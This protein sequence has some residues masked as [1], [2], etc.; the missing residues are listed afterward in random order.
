M[1][2]GLGVDLGTTSTAAAVVVGDGR[3]ETVAL[4]DRAA[5][6]PSAVFLTDEGSELLG[7]AALRRGVAEPHRLA[8]EFKRRLGDPTPL[9]LGGRPVSAETLSGHLLRWVVDEVRARQGGPPNRIVVTHPANWGP[10]RREVFGQALG[11]AD[12]GRVD[13][14]PEPVAAALH[15]AACERVPSG[16]TVAVYDLGGGT[17]DATVL[18]DTGQGYQVLGSPGGL[19]HLGGVDFDE[20]VLAHVTSSLGDA[21]TDL[22]AD[23]DDVTR[24]LVRL[25]E[26]CTAAKE[27][28][29]SDTEAVLRVELPGV[30]RDVRITRPEFEDLLRP[31]SPRPSPA[32]VGR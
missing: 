30:R 27:H 2:Y 5:D 21:L 16:G 7:E 26:E 11:I 13:T 28:L 22:D 32:C 24:A 29:S 12:V 14:L 31:R 23:D 10:F 9:V 15:F 8:R 18:R 3:P 25:R 20:A 4:G 6:V 1:G 17:F 19:E